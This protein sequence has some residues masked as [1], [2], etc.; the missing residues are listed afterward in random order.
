MAEGKRVPLYMRLYRTMRRR[1]ETGAWPAGMRLL[2]VREQ[3]ATLGVSKFTVERVYGQLAAEGYIR[4]RNRAR[5]EV[6]SLAKVPVAAKASTHA[7]RKKKAYRYDFISAAMDRDG[8]RFGEWRRFFY[9]TL[10]QEERLLEYGDERGEY[11]LRAALA[12]YGADA[13]DT[14]AGP[15]DI[16]IGASTQ[17]LLRILAGLLR[18]DH[19]EVAFAEDGFPLGAD[20]FADEGYRPVRLGGGSLVESLAATA[21][22]LVYV[23][24]SY[25]YR[26][27]GVMPA[28]V[29][30][31][32]LAWC[33]ACDGLIIED[34]FDSEL[35]YYGQP[36]S[37]LQGMGG[38]ERVV[39]M[40]SLSRVL[41]PS[42]RVAYMIL[43][44]ALSAR[45]EE[46]RHL[47]RQTASV[48]EQLTLAEYIRAGELA[49]QIRRLRRLYEEKGAALAQA[50]TQAF[51]QAIRVEVP[52]A[53]VYCRVQ[54]QTKLPREAFIRAAAAAGIG[55]RRD[56]LGEETGWRSFVLAF[57][58]MP[59]EDFEGAAE[60]LYEV[61]EKVARE[62]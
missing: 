23:V 14:D 57:G 58:R 60:A 9:R 19:R 1:I 24:P 3:A 50:L 7:V 41:P 20:T 31:D 21:A 52:Q 43:P 27:Q 37:S 8:F 45:Y 34:D 26:S 5:Y 4:P 40:G 33:E 32:L 38:R 47:Y 55:L 22:R 62:A 30:A 48:A 59:R 25:T 11:E 49:K 61:Y 15:D 12:Q 44:P 51:G 53:G 42:F 56:R 35:C 39:Y 16:V 28:Q 29:R 54:I 17:Q 2:S 10:R 18:A 6:R 13:R 46:R 36:L